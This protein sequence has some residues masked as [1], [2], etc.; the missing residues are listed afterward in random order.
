MR[1][2]AMR[3]GLYARL[4]PRRPDVNFDYLLKQTGMFSYTGLTLEQVRKLR[5]EFAIYV[6]ESGRICVAALTRKALAPVA[7][8]MLRVLD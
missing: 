1:I 5:D 6:V 4:Q 7:D 8:A 2:K 3:E